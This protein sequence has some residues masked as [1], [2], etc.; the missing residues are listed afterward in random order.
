MKSLQVLFRIAAKNVG[1]HWRHSLAAIISISASF[2]SLVVFQG[3]MQDVNLMYLE[4]FR[5][6]LM[7][8]D[9]IIEN[10]M[11]QKEEG[12]G[13]PLKYTLSEE[14]QLKIQSILNS[15]SHHIDSSVRFLSV[16][17]IILGDSTSTI[18]KGYGYDVVSGAKMRGE[19]W[20]WN[21]VYGLPLQQVDASSSL[22]VGQ[23]LAQ[24]LGCSPIKKEKIV[25]GVAGY[26]AKDRPFSCVAPLMQLIATTQ[27]GQLNATNLEVKG[28][29]DAAYKD[30]DNKFVAMDLDQAQ[31]LLNTK[32]LSY[33]TV[34]FH[35]SSIADKLINQFNESMNKSHPQIKMLRWQDH[36]VGD[37][38]LRTMDLLSVFRNFVV[39]III[40]IAGLS[41]FNTMLKVVKERTR[42]IGVLQSL[43]FWSWHI[44]TIFTIESALLALFGSL[45]GALSAVSMTFILNLLGI[46][47]K[48]GI[49]VEPVRFHVL[50]DPGLYISS[51]VLLSFLSILTAVLAVRSNLN[52]QAS[53]NLSDN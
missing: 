22:I 15:W 35:D 31:S 23:S 27:H 38:Y 19:Q 26:E 48:A 46:V 28:L 6:R 14:E 41:I 44:A 52:R 16:D 40:T 12:K 33:I 37:I 32:A 36:P 39:I 4:T 13:D 34:K 1:L 47:Y 18:M 45:I 17:G 25:N 50:I 2:V 49:L 30:I 8:G 11:M 29:V 24:I 9:V 21:T 53:D 43:G 42:E 7:Y 20:A 10:E 5:S 3:Y 51:M